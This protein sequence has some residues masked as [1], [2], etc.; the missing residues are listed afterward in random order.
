MTTSYI[1][2]IFKDFEAPV[3]EFDGFVIIKQSDEFFGPT[4]N[5][6]T[7]QNNNDIDNIKILYRYISKD[8]AQVEYRDSDRTVILTFKNYYNSSNISYKLVFDKNSTSSYNNFKKELSTLINTTNRTLYYNSGNEKYLGNISSEDD[9]HVM[10][11]S[12]TLYYNN[13]N[14]NV[15]YTGEFED[16]MFDG[17]GR[18]QNKEGSI[19]LI[20]NNISNG[21][22]NTKG[23]LFINFREMNRTIEINFLDFWTKIKIDSKNDRRHLVK[24][25]NFVKIIATH[26]LDN[27]K[28]YIENMLF[29]D[30]S[31][32]QQNMI[33]WKK[34]DDMKKENKFNNEQT[35]KRHIELINTIAIIGFITITSLIFNLM[36]IFK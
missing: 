15:K 19:V 31:T 16:N 2:K 24:S 10:N 14:H 4:L 35:D 17:A 23:K 33:I 13:S 25:D 26:Y 6:Q 3:N 32:E 8:F 12:G 1:V 7:K 29:E 22:P 21:I 9:N 11:G 5:L 20:A 18:F 27:G 30:K 34:L 28:E 36:L